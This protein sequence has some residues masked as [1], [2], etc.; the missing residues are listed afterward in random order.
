MA[1]LPVPSGER[2]LPT[3]NADGTRRWL[4]PKPADGPHQRR[5]YYFAWFLIA[6]FTVIPHIQFGG[7]PL[8]LLDVAHR[9]FT[10]FGVTL[11]PTDNLLLVLLLLTLGLGVFAL[12][13]VLG[14]V[15]CGWACPQ[16]VYMEFVYRPVERFF[17]GQPG[18]RKEKDPWSGVKTAAKYA[19][20]VAISLFLAHTFLA[21]FVGVE[22]LA[23]WVRQS[24]LDHPIPFAIMAG[25]TL[26]MLADF[27]FFREQVCLVACPYGRFQSVL[28]DKNSMIV[29][30]DAKR[31]EPRGHGK[32]A[33]DA[34]PLGDCVD[35]GACLRCCPTGID[36]R[37]GLQMECIHCTQ[38]IDACDSVM[39]KLKRPAGLIRYTTKAEL[40]GEPPRTVRPRLLLYGGIMAV[41]FSGFLWM[42]T[43]RSLADV[44][45]LRA[46]DTP[47]RLLDS[48]EVQNELRVKIVN[49]DAGPRKYS[50]RIVGLPPE[51]RVVNPM[52]PVELNVGEAKT[53][54]LFVFTPREFL[55]MGTKEVTLSVSDGQDFSAEFP[56][57]LLGP[58][59][60]TP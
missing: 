37:Q 56:Y 1:I 36:I 49:R 30:Y 24:P 16:T 55:G 2:V 25:T 40:A 13:A 4:N 48:G 52:D 19:T 46:I 59:G 7:K 21:W 32:P 53:T 6:L 39:D 38:C 33:P 10:F 8:V 29:G 51:A 28:L 34:P 22:E 50:I 14:R 15:W 41:A 54:A 5:R 44:I 3:L 47:Y 26:A 42:L 12:T 58:K 31:G 35:C 27:G 45:V 43:H 23:R 20:F 60:V 11:L 57:R 18:H 17:D 9:Q